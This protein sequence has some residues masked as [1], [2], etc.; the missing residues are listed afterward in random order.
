[1]AIVTDIEELFT[2]QATMDAEAQTLRDTVTAAHP[3]RASDYSPRPIRLLN[4][5]DVGTCEECGE[6]EFTVRDA[7]SGRTLSMC[8]MCINAIRR[9]SL[10]HTQYGRL[11]ICWVCEIT[12]DSLGIIDGAIHRTKPVDDQTLPGGTIRHGI[13]PYLLAGRIDNTDGVLSI[14]EIP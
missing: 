9:G 6:P 1:M 12:V 2:R 4:P 8:R 10:L 11:E 13:M 3:G 14:T 7:G 5:N